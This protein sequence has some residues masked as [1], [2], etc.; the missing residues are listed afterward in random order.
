MDSKSGAFGVVGEGGSEHFLETAEATFSAGLA[1][2]EVTELSGITITTRRI[3]FLLGRED[4]KVQML[5]IVVQ[6][7]PAYLTL[8]SR[9]PLEV[10][11]AS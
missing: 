4:V 10:G 3:R 1:Y 5:P 7:L 2:F 8:L 6:M 11:R 9:D